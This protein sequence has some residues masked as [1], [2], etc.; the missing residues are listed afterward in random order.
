MIIKICHWICSVLH[1]CWCYNYLR[2]LTQ[3]ST[4]SALVQLMTCP[5]S[6]VI[7]QCWLMIDGPSVKKG[8]WNQQHWKQWVVM[9]PTVLLFVASWVLITTIYGVTNNE[10]IGIMTNLGGFKCWPTVTNFLS[11]E[12]IWNTDRKI[13]SYSA[14]FPIMLAKIGRRGEQISDHQVNYY[15]RKLLA[16]GT[17]GT[18]VTLSLLSMDKVG[19]MAIIP[20]PSASMVVN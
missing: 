9:I 15:S 16:T 3:M 10:R 17:G 12:H 4:G 20:H 1:I 7:D 8:H 13:A 18:L 6:V 14:G 2:L 19:M 11:R 5:C